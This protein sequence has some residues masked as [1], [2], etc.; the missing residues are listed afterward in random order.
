[1]PDPSAIAAI[2]GVRKIIHIDM[3]AFHASVEQRA[4]LLCASHNEHHNPDAGP[5]VRHALKPS[6][7]FARTPG[8]D[9]I[10]RSK[11]SHRRRSLADRVCAGAWIRNLLSKADA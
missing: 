4:S 8:L 7:G 11:N 3:D 9:A 1:M 5:P 10:S 6:H 2:P